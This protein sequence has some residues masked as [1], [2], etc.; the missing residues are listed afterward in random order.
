LQA[1][2]L[3]VL[4]AAQA[5]YARGSQLAAAVPA[6]ETVVASADP[7]AAFPACITLEQALV[8]GW[9]DFDPPHSLVTP[10]GNSADLLARLRQSAE[11][12]SCGDVVIRARLACAVADASLAAISTQPTPTLRSCPSC[13]RQ[14]LAGT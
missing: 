14:A 11:G 7:D 10:G 4:T 6:P 12:L 9:F 2:K 3:D 5:L 1:A 8:D 13:R